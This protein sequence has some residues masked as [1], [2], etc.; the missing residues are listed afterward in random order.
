VV[1]GDYFRVGG[2]SMA[3]AVVSGAVALALEAHPDWTPDQVKE[4]LVRSAR[5]VPGVGKEVAVDGAIEL[6]PGV[7][8]NMQT[9]ETHSLVDAAT[10]EIDYT[11]A[12]WRAASWRGLTREDP[13]A[14]SFSAASWRCDCSLQDSGGI[15][16][17][18]ASWRAASWRT[19]F[20]R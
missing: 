16:P 10:G 5:D 3:A 14:A 1:D 15:D 6:P 9:W 19:S 8:T 12:S 17:K 7:L 18:A 4:A 11:A 20:K 2:T 13:L